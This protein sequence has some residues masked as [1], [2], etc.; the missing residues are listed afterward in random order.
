MES[1]VFTRTNP[2]HIAGLLKRSA[3]GRSVSI[4]HVDAEF[5]YQSRGRGA[6]E[7]AEARFGMV[8]VREIA[9][10]GRRKRLPHSVLG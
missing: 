3:E 5:L 2:K 1:G 9:A 10:I 8:V 7:R 4:G 6:A